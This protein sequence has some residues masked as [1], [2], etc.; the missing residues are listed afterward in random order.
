MYKEYK[1]DG[2]EWQERACNRK[3]EKENLPGP[4]DMSVTRLNI[5]INVWKGIARPWIQSLAHTH[6]HT[7]KER[8]RERERERK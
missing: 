1:R 3:R 2:R 5:F 4:E 8:E 7:E 6:M